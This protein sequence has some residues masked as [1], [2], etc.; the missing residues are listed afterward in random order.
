MSCNSTV[1]TTT[2]QQRVVFSRSKESQ[3]VEE[4]VGKGEEAYATL[5]ILCKD[6]PGASRLDGTCVRDDCWDR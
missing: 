2:S 3:V 6:A 5:E 4:S 1:Q